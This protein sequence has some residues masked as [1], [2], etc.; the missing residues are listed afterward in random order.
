MEKG[1]SVGPAL[2]RALT[3]RGDGRGWVATGE[4]QPGF[5]SETGSLSEAAGKGTE[6]G[7]EARRGVGIP[8]AATTGRPG[9]AGRT[10]ADA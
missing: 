1:E 4:R 9:P 5:L 3:G 2:T 8:A 7:M 6:A 10:G